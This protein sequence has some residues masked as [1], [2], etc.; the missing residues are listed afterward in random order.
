MIINNGYRYWSKD[1]EYFIPNR[2]WICKYCGKRLYTTSC[3]RLDYSLQYGLTCGEFY[4]MYKDQLRTCYICDELLNRD[5]VID[6]DHRWGKKVDDIKKNYP[7]ITERKKCVRGLA[8]SRC[9]L[10]ISGLDNIFDYEPK[11]TL[12]VLS[13]MYSKIMERA[14]MKPTKHQTNSHRAAKKWDDIF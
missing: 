9:N 4:Q 2:G 3:F 11:S 6:H 12:K 8:H 5:V 1:K 7:A 13:R 10:A 14:N